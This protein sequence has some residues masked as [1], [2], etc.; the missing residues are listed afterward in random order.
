[1]KAIRLHTYHEQPVLD[2]VPEPGI[3]GPLDVIVEVGGAGLCRTDLHIIEGQWAEKSGV[4]LPYTLGHENAGWVREIGSGV[5][6]VAAGDGDPLLVHLDGTRVDGDGVR[7][8]LHRARTVRVS[9]DANGDYC[10]Q[11]LAE[12]YGAVAAT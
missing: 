11:L 1:M 4:T 8:H 10:R 2:D 7:V 9:I 5:T 3:E 12:R 6:N